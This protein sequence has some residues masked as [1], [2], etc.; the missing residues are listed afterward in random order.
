MRRILFTII[1]ILLIYSFIELPSFLGL[2]LLKKIRHIEYNPILTASLSQDHQ[3]TLQ[4][5]IIGKTTY[6]IH[7]PVLGWTIKPN[8]FWQDLY[9][10]NSKGLR[11]GREYQAMPS[12]N[13]IRISSFGDSY[14]HCDDVKNEETW[15]E[16]LQ[17]ADHRLEVLNF[18]VG[19][20]GLDQ[21]FLRYSEEGK[22][23]NSHI[24]LIGFMKENINRL[25]NVFRPFYF[26]GIPLTKPRYFIRENE[27]IL[28]N[29][30]LS[31]F[32]DCSVLLHNPKALLSK[33]GE[34]DYYYKILPKEHFLDFSPSVRLFKLLYYTIYNRY[35][36]NSGRTIYNKNGSYNQNSEA[37]K[38][39]TKLFDEFY[40]LA[41]KNK[42]LPIIILFPGPED[43]KQYHKN[44]IKSYSSLIHY[45]DSRGY[46]Y[47]DLLDVFE[48]YGVSSHSD[49]I[50]GK[51]Y[52]HSPLGN[53]NV[54]KAILDYLKENNFTDLHV[55]KTHIEKKPLLDTN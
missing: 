43:I 3:N 49:D 9:R 34:N 13:S 16:Q 4:N 7:S 21:A 23:Y 8:G 31:T 5:L 27:L 36:G 47:I 46:R 14:T 6:L 52:H 20:Y 48:R 41:Q 2:L 45:F 53:L 51:F 15:Q 25:V 55:I 1:I 18:G 22:L 19:G 12:N 50:F 26:P 39:C 24:I 10:S 40:C 44:R 30:P 35:L 54:A 11:G 29:N 32:N 38:I 37:F 33:F 42:S 17:N 28:L